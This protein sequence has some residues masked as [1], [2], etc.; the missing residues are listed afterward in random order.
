MN[1]VGIAFDQF[2][3]KVLINKK[4]ILHTFRIELWATFKFSLWMWHV[5]PHKCCHIHNIGRT[6]LN[7]LK[8][9]INN[10]FELYDLLNKNI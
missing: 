2:G 1:V 3:I 9:I 10:K 6:F 5:R 8:Q 7:L 4:I